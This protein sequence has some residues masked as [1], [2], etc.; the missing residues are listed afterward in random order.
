[1]DDS[2]VPVFLHHYYG[3]GKHAKV[4]STRSNDWDEQKQGYRED[5]PLTGDES[6]VKA[7][8]DVEFP[9]LLDPT[10]DL[11]PATIITWPREGLMAKLEDGVLV[12]RGTTT[13]NVA[14]RR[15][16]VNGVKA[17]DVDCGY[18]Q[19]EARLPG[20]EPGMLTVVAH[21]VDRAGNEERTAHRISVHISK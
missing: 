9:K 20:V 11:P 12:V 13:D 15:V 18:H 10:D 5:P 17:R 14:T 21:A 19:W 4:V 7:V 8:T 16:M 3:K 6:R 1:M 2:S